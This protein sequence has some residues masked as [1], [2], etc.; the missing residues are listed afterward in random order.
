ML[1]GP[2]G[3]ATSKLSMPEIDLNGTSLRDPSRLFYQ[4]D[5]NRRLIIASYWAVI[6][7]ALPLWWYTTSIERLSLPSTR[8]Y[9]QTGKE[10]RFPVDV[11]LDASITRSDASLLHQ[12]QHL[13]DELVRHAPDR[14]KGLEVRFSSKP[15]SGMSLVSSHET[16]SYIQVLDEPSYS[17]V[18]GNDIYVRDRHLTFPVEHGTC[19]SSDY[20]Y[21]QSAKPHSYKQYPPWSIAWLDF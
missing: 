11:H 14:W 16:L 4:L 21:V 19:E 17:I 20:L 10:L 3:T 12:L 13:V 6:L 15:D 1:C 7:C 8:V 2:D 5:Y 9:S 18:F